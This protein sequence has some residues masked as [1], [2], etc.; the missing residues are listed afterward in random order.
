MKNISLYITEK[1]HIDKEV[2]ATKPDLSNVRAPFIGPERKDFEKMRDYHAKGSKPE[3][4]VNSIK[5]N[6]KLARRFAVA[7]NMKWDAAID[8]FGK[9]LVDR[10]VYRQEEVDKYIEVH[11]AKN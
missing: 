4:L 11:Y 3:R 10:G 9:A 1:L 5:D 8:E 6:E 7:V 2:K